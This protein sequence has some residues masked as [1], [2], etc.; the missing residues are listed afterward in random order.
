MTAAALLAA[1]FAAGPAR[2]ALKPASGPKGF[3]A[4]LR[5][6]R[7]THPVAAHGALQ[8][9]RCVRAGSADEDGD[10]VRFE[11]PGE[12][13]F[14]YPSSFH[15]QNAWKDSVPTVYLT[16]DGPTA[17][18]PVAITVARYDPGQDDYRSLEEAVARD[19]SWQSAQDLGVATVAGRRARVT[20]VAGEARS[21]YLPAAEESYYSFVYSAP[22]DAYAKHLPAFARLLRT[23]RLAGR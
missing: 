20:A 13:S 19:V 11:V 5:C 7:G 23:L 12:I 3:A 14:E 15:P 17:G 1:A 2:A 4:P 9:F 10:P 6:P 21:V 22:A 8:A 16:L 18:K